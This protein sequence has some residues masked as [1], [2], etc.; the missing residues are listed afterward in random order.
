MNQPTREEFEDLKE[1]VR[2]LEEQITEPIKITRLEIDSGSMHKRLDLVQEDM[3]VL[4]EDAGILKEDVS[5]LKEDVSVLK[6]DV[7]VLKEEMKGARADI[8]Q[9]RESQA[10]LRDRLIEHGEDLKVIKEK[11]DAHTD[12]L[13]QLISI[14]EDHTKSFTDIKERLNTTATKDDIA[15]IKA[16]QDEQ[17]DLLK[18]ILAEQRKPRGE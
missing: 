2:K 13:D 4:K 16:N 7:S 6:E 15:A 17:G 14:G 11:Q 12:I 8:L 18:L 3:T 10:D 1:K 9:I 5:V